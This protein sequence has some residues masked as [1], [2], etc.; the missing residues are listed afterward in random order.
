VDKKAEE[1]YKDRLQEIVSVI[2][3]ESDRFEDVEGKII[4]EVFQVYEEYAARIRKAMRGIKDDILIE[5]DFMDH[6]KIAAALCCSVLKVKPITFKDDGPA[7]FPMEE[8]A[9]ELCAYLLGLQAVQNYWNT[10]RE[11]EKTPA[12]EKMIYNHIIEG[13]TPEDSGTTYQDW[14]AKLVKK[15]AFQYFDYGNPDLFEVELIFF[16]SHIYFLI[17]RH[18]YQYYKGGK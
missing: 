17:E 6:H 13:A 7:R 5:D 4:E 11:G 12:E 14:F 1:T 8:S 15:E 18:S 10:M 3:K 2:L 9:N 16:I